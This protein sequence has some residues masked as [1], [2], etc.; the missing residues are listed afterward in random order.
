[1][2]SPKKRGQ[3]SRLVFCISP[4]LPPV[5]PFLVIFECSFYIPQGWI[6]KVQ[7]GEEQVKSLR[8]KK[9]MKS[10]NSS[11][12]WV[13]RLS[14]I[15]AC[16]FEHLRRDLSTELGPAVD[17]GGWFSDLAVG[18]KKTTRFLQN[19]LPI[20]SVSGNMETQCSLP[21][22]FE[23]HPSACCPG[24][25][26][27]RGGSFCG[28]WT[29]RETSERSHGSL[30]ARAADLFWEVVS[31][32]LGIFWASE[33]KY[34]WFSGL[35]S[36]RLCTAAVQHW[37]G[38]GGERRTWR[39]ISQAG[40]FQLCPMGSTENILAPPNRGFRQWVGVRFC[41]GHLFLA[42]S[43]QNTKKCYVSDW[44]RLFPKMVASQNMT[45]PLEALIFPS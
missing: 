20:R 2:N 16:C 15:F 34:G 40:C 17:S 8:E 4:V 25:P 23:P 3:Y 24:P 32:L 35:A 31:D 39:W 28:D 7:Q 27:A 21:L 38:A 9:R 14:H 43:T 26:E 45:P 36:G 19:G 29:R 18:R 42:H 41:M 5:G 37:R 22:D 30:W 11:E 6:N 44:A 12:F 33:V 13:L 10:M 1:M